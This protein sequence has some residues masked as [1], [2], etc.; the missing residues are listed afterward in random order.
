MKCFEWDENSLSEF[1]GSTHCLFGWGQPMLQP[2]IPNGCHRILIRK[3]PAT[4]IRK[5]IAL[6]SQ[7]ESPSVY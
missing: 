4:C 2:M 3:I 5:S 6:R 1:Q 7:N